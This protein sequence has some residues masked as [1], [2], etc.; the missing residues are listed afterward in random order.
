MNRAINQSFD[1]SKIPLLDPSAGYAQAR[2]RVL[3]AGRNTNEC[4]APW[5]Q[6][7]STLTHLSEQALGTWVER[8][9]TDLNSEPRKARAGIPMN[10]N[11]LSHRH[12]TV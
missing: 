11:D 6:R 8:P 2:I 10:F 3:V 5:I 4:N 7:G 12:L 9:A 1:R